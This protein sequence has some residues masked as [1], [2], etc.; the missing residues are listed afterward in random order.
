MDRLLI[1]IVQ[2]YSKI[3]EKEIKALQKKRTTGQYV[4]DTNAN[5]FYF[6]LKMEFRNLHFKK[7]FF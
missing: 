1:H 2:N 4:M 6:V 3:G 7:K 5:I